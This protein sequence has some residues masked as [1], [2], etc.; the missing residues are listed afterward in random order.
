MYGTQT[1]KLYK[2][3]E[4]KFENDVNMYGTQTAK[5][6]RLAESKFENDVN[7]YGTQTKV[8]RN[9]YCYGLRMM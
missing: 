9:G 5:L 4:R 1:A 7:M 6:Y 8:F 3:A 2:L